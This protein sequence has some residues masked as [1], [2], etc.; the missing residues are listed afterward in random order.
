MST[1]AIYLTVVIFILALLFS[2]YGWFV[3]NR[4]SSQRSTISMTLLL[5]QEQ[6]D[7]LSRAHWVLQELGQAPS[8]AESDVL[9]KRSQ[10]NVDKWIAMYE[11]LRISHKELE[12]VL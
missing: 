6:Q 4:L 5:M 8:I 9:S 11:E 10:E 12:R 3:A 2:V 1:D 7:A